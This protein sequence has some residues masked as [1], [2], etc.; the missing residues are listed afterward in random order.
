VTGLST[1]WPNA[2]VSGRSYARPR[3]RGKFNQSTR[4]CRSRIRRKL[5]FSVDS[6][7]RIKRIDVA[8]I[9]GSLANVGVIAGSI[10]VWLEFRQL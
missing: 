8:Q 3:E 10:L 1:S 4:F 5:V 7:R 6:R 9:V 2:P